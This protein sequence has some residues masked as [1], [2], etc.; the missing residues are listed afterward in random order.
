MGRIYSIE[1]GPTANTVKIDF[2]S[3]VPADDKPCILHAIY[4]GQTTEFGDAQEEQIE[5]LIVR[6]GTAM[7]SGSGGAA[8]TPRPVAS[9]ADAAA[10]FTARTLDTT[11]ATFTAGVNVHRDTFNVRNGWQYLP[12]PED[13]IGV[14]QANGGLACSMTGAPADSITW[15]VTAIIEE[16][17]G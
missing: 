3:I 14:S 11:V 7:T 8:P 10:G 6:G 16:I 17:G 5:V 13:R 9:S 12:S 15:T 2:F 4:I 1:G